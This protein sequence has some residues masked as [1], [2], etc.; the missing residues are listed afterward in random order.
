MVNGPS[1]G[2]ALAERP[3]LL[4]L[5]DTGKEYLGRLEAVEAGTPTA[6]EPKGSEILR[7]TDFKVEAF[8]RQGA[9]SPETKR[10]YEAF[11]EKHG[12]GADRLTKGASERSEAT[13]ELLRDFSGLRLR[14]GRSVVGTKVDAGLSEGIESVYRGVSRG[15]EVAKEE[16][17]KQLEFLVSPEEWAKIAEALASAAQNPIDF[18]DRLITAVKDGGGEV[19]KQVETMWAASTKTGF[20]AEMG[21]YVPEVGIPFLIGSV[22]PG[23]FFKILKLDKL[24][25]ESLAKKLLGEAEAVAVAGKREVLSVEKLR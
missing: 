16:L 9:I 2:F 20:S 3:E 23:K 17:K 1:E 15:I 14:D 4:A 13:A 21:R 24:L 12:K 18:M 8:E 19:W 25:P 10:Q 5:N 7:Q 11:L 6:G 22:G